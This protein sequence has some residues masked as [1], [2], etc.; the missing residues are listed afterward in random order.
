MP[1]PD[2]DGFQRYCEQHYRPG[3]AK[4]YATNARTLLEFM[5]ACGLSNFAQ[6]PPNLLIHYDQ[7]LTRCAYTPATTHAKLA[8]AKAYLR[9]VR[10]LCDVPVVEQ[11]KVRARKIQTVVKEALDPSDFAAYF[12]AANEE[13]EPLRTAAMLLVCSG[14]RSQELL[15]LSVDDV[16]STEIELSNGEKRKVLCLVV[17]K[18]KGG[19]RRTVPL[20][21]EGEE[22][23][24]QYF[25]GPWQALAA[26]GRTRYL[27]PS[28]LY[29]GQAAKTRGLRY[30]LKRISARLGLDLTPH[31]LRR[32]YLTQLH[33][34][35]VDFATVSKI[36][37]HEDPQT[38]YKHY[39]ALSSSDLASAVYERGGS[40]NGRG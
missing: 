6:V 38:L 39:L 27:F 8:A 12:T 25:D 24:R 11:R 17:Q 37:G 21:E 18:G 10:D 3:S 36:A 9:W 26:E 31:A 23:L 5:Q 20:L 15:D 13:S 35:G 7:W 1:A 30:A 29:L 14:V 40:L 16:Q 22:V 33:R 32:T 4:A 2:L 28:K 19:K 34:L